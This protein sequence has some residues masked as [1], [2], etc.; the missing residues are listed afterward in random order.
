MK[1]LF[2]LID[3][4]LTAIVRSNRGK[5]FIDPLTI[6]GIVGGAKL[7]TKFFSDRAAKKKTERL[8]AERKKELAQNRKDSERGLNVAKGIARM[9]DPTLAQK[10]R[11]INQAASDAIGKTVATSGSSQEVLNAIQGIQKNK[12]IA[13]GTAESQAGATKMGAAQFYANKFSE[14]GRQRILG[15]GAIDRRTQM[16][17]GAIQQQAQSNVDTVSNIGGGIMDAKIYDDLRKGKL[18]PDQYNIAQGNPVT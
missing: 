17:L 5:L 4:I 9:G 14:S 15:E 11:D 8:E 18:M 10:K 1:N 7:V 2:R 6:G 12:D 16:A 3:T 13:T